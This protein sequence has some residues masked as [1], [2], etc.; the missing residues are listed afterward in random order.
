MDRIGN[1]L[2]RLG[3]L[4]TSASRSKLTPS[5]KVIAQSEAFDRKHSTGNPAAAE[6]LGRLEARSAKSGKSPR[7]F[8]KAPTTQTARL[9]TVL[10]EF[11]PDAGDDFSGFERPAFVGAEECVTEPAGTLLGGPLH[12][13][14]PDPAT[15]GR[16][17]DNNTFWV[18]DFSPSHYNKLIYTKTGLTRRVRPDLTGP[19]GKPG[20]NLRG[21][22]VKN[23]YQEMSKGAY[24][25]TGQV[26]GWVQVPHSEA[27]YGATVCGQP[28]QDNSGHPDNPRQVSQL[29]VDAVDAL[30]AGDPD[31]PWADYDIEDQGDADGDGAEGTYSIWSHAG[32]VDPSTGGYAVPGT[33]VR[34]NNYIMQA[35]DA[36]VGVI[37]H[38]YGHDLGLPDLYDTSGAA[39]SDVDFWDLMASGS[40]TGPLCQTIPVHMG[41]WDKYV[42]GWVDPET[43]G[44]GSSGRSV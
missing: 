12:N 35:V 11:N 34:V 8:K 15:V 24:D 16:G 39:D 44:V 30:A 26:A 31:F 32:N 42:L 9:L 19:D 3:R 43:F 40:H 13:N 18:P 36:G 5:A 4:S 37:S 7:A 23:H 14:M 27:W 22:T 28:M 2:E 29:I 10:V 6:V 1:Q 33:E 17:T 20:V 41:L 25:I 21:Y 38:E